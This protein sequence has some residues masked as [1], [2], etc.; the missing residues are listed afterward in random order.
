MRRLPWTKLVWVG[1]YALICGAEFLLAWAKERV[2]ER[3]KGKAPG[4]A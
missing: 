4:A 3:I 2:A 1:L